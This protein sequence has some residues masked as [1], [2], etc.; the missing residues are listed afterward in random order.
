[1][2][3]TAHVKIMMKDMEELQQRVE[4]EWDDFDQKV[5]NSAI[6]LRD[7]KPALQLTDNSS[8]MHFELCTHLLK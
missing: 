7:C 5:I 2:L 6:R 8:T 4:E 3:S 1:M